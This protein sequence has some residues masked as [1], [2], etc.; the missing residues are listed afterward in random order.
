MRKDWLILGI[1]HTFYQTLVGGGVTQKSTQEEGM[2]SLLEAHRL[3][4]KERKLTEETGDCLCLTLILTQPYKGEPSSPPL[5]GC[6]D[7]SVW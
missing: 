1:T 7:S 3:D 2:E 4:G 6:P 5:Y